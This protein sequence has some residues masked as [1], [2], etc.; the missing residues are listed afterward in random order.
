[1]ALCRNVLVS[2]AF[3]GGH[4]DVNEYTYM[5]PYICFMT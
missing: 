5:P 3:L 2:H 4:M 1:M